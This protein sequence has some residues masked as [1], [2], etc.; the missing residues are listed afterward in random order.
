MPDTRAVVHNPSWD[1]VLHGLTASGIVAVTVDSPDWTSISCADPIFRR[2]LASSQLRLCLANLDDF[3]LERVDIDCLDDTERQRAAA[4]TH[5]VQRHRFVM[6]RCL[7][8]QQLAALTGIEAKS[9]QL[10]VLPHG[11]PVLRDIEGLAFNLA[12]T[13]P[14]WLLGLAA[15]D[16]VGVDLERIRPLTDLQRLAKRVFSEAEQAELSQIKDHA[17]QQAAFFRGWTRKEAVLKALGTG[18]TLPARSLHIGLGVNAQAWCELAEGARLGVQSGLTEEGLLWATASPFRAISL[19]GFR[20]VAS[21]H[22]AR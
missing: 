4:I 11:K 10:N 22:P 17:L 3:P 21:R 8:R 2:P 14:F 15:G 18:F 20:L 13:G 1:G 16:A 19:E 7:L 5:A 12:H 6:S 9:L